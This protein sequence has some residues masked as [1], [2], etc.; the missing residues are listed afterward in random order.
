[1]HSPCKL[2]KGHRYAVAISAQEIQQNMMCSKDRAA[3]SP[4]VGSQYLILAENEKKFIHED[5]NKMETPDHFHKFR[6]NS[7]D[8]E[9]YY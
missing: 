2:F 6:F 3:S 7:L 9:L 4:G 5:M 8:N 1:M